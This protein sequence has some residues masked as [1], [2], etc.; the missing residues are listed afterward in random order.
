MYLPYLFNLCS[1]KT[2]T[3]HSQMHTMFFFIPSLLWQPFILPETSFI[4][5]LNLYKAKSHKF[6]TFF[7]KVTLSLDTFQCLFNQRTL[8][9]ILI[10][11]RDLP[12]L[13]VFSL[14]LKNHCIPP[15]CPSSTSRGFSLLFS[16]KAL[17]IKSVMLSSVLM[18]FRFGFVV[19]ILCHL[20]LC[21]L[22]FF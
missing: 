22:N 19:G 20:F 7:K 5:F 16:H 17:Y 21:I 2:L 9:F 6:F 1:W 12:Q 8:G 15:R 11:L 18:H 14:L 13:E 10:L 3:W 4:L